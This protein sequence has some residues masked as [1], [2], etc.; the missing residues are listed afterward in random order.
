MVYTT[1]KN[2]D[3]CGDGLWH[4]F[5]HI[6]SFSHFPNSNKQSKTIQLSPGVTT[7]LHSYRRMHDSLLKKNSCNVFC[8]QDLLCNSTGSST[9]FPI[10]GQRFRSFGRRCFSPL[11]MLRLLQKAGAD[12]SQ[13]TSL[14][15]SAL[16]LV[17]QQ[18][19]QFEHISALVESCL[20][21]KTQQT[22]GG[23]LSHGAPPNHP[24]IS[25]Y[26]IILV[27]KPM[28]TWGSPILRNH[29]FSLVEIGSDVGF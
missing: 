1:Y 22:F 29:H 15:R 5:N 18:T 6:I 13:K 25:F 28:V 27:L 14:G 20:G 2:R 23:V 12:S 10:L 16:Q 17:D 21:W 8:Q 7:V 19:E 9:K 24:F 4:S 3:N 11:R 26:Q